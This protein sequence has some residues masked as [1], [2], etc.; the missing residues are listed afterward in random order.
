VTSRAAAVLVLALLLAACA[1]ADGGGAGPAPDDLPADDDA[2]VLQVAT[3]G[4]FTTAEEQAGR[5][6]V[7]SVYADGRAVST[8]PVAAV[9][10]GPAWP[11]VL[12]AQ[13]DPGQLR[14]LLDRAVDAGAAAEDD[15][16]R[17]G[18]ADAPTTR[19]TVW[20]DGRTTVREVYALG[21][22]VGDP[23][24]TDEQQAARQ[25]LLDLVGDLPAGEEPFT[26]GA[27][28]VLAAPPVG[29]PGQPAVAWPGP[30]LPGEPLPGGAPCTLVT[31]DAAR[32][33]TE[34]AR[35]A[36]AQTPWTTPDGARWA[37]TFRPLL[38]HESGCADL[39]G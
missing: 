35:Q 19:F 14:A 22:G 10:P 18:V 39:A 29:D 9:F 24:L 25:R 1:R 23:Q 11:N 13:L 38:P 3:V 37:L 27:V 16:G 34:A 6:P 2:L 31:G 20:T 36:N 17:P 30:A 12:V 26:P 4:G 33:V 8:G 5:L 21:E 32:T 28:A 15:L 7:V